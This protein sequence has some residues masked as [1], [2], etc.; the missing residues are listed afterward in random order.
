MQT[1]ACAV[2]EA[3]SSCLAPCS[4]IP[5]VT[6]VCLSFP[7]N[8]LVL[9]PNTEC[10]C[11]LHDGILGL[12]LT[13]SC[14]GQWWEHGSGVWRTEMSLCTAAYKL[15]LWAALPTCKRGIKW[16]RVCEGV[17]CSVSQ[18]CPI[19]CGPSAV[20]VPLCVDFS[21]Q[22]YNSRVSSWPG[23]W[24][25]VSRVSCTGSRSVM[26]DSTTSWTVARQATLSM[27]FSR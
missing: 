20:H 25:H 5:Q 11:M 8:V 1:S 7:P 24:T 27:G 9:H 19:L 4:Q 15:R 22:E 16:H 14:A 3:V 6:L 26:S 13:Q 12:H 2:E 23:D 17:V 21:R 18:L 10:F